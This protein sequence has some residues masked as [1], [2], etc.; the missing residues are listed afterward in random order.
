[1]AKCGIRILD[2]KREKW[3]SMERRVREG[4]RGE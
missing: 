1:M 2:R 4:E 3:L